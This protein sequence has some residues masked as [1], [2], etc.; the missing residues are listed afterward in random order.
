MRNEK[1]MTRILKELHGVNDRQLDLVSIIYDLENDHERVRSVHTMEILSQERDLDK[2]HIG[3]SWIYIDVNLIKKFGNTDEL[4]DYLDRYS[5]PVESIED[6]GEWYTVNTNG[7]YARFG[8][9]LE[10][11]HLHIIVKYDVSAISDDEPL[12]KNFKDDYQ[13]SD[14]PASDYY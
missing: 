9:E 6:T 1:N 10:E 11:D 13:K 2:E 12:D 7:I 14:I 5:I 8:N 4:K 3:K